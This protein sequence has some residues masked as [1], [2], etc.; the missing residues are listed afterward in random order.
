MTPDGRRILQ[1]LMR[2]S[3]HAPRGS[4]RLR[5]IAISVLDGDSERAAR[6]LA[7]LDAEGYIRTDAMGWPS[8]RLT[9]KAQGYDGKEK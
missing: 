8:G 4:L 2:A 3:K 6:A 5:K 9:D 7:E 1:V